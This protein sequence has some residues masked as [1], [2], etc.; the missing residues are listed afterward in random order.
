MEYNLLYNTLQNKFIYQLRLIFI[1][2]IELKYSKLNGI[3]IWMMFIYLSLYNITF[4]RYFQRTYI[5][6]IPYYIKNEKFLNEH[7]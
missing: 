1:S 7:L 5:D 2:K 3:Y 6:N 4:K